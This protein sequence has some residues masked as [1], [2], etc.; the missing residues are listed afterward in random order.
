MLGAHRSMSIIYQQH[1]CDRIVIHD[2]LAAKR[3]K[4]KEI[5]RLVIP[6][7]PLSRCYSWDLGYE[8]V[9]EVLGARL[10]QSQ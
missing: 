4:P 8:R 9:A 5:P 10:P 2:E 3:K 6:T 7:G 1:V